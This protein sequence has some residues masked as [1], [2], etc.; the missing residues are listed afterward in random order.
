MLIKSSDMAAS[1]SAILPSFGLGLVA[2]I[3]S[4]TALSLYRRS[5][6][7]K[8]SGHQYVN[9]LYHDGDGT[10]T[11]DSQRA[12][13]TTK[14]RSLALLASVVGF[15][16]STAAVVIETSQSHRALFP[17]SWSTLTSWVRTVIL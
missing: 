12:F 17:E 8:V 15:A 13:S 7:R 1:P 10:A 9:A 2:A 11:V 6:S 4:P 16:L 3:S 14:L 5:R